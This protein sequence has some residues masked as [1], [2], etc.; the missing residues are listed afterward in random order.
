MITS[1]NALQH[2]FWGVLDS[3]YTKREQKDGC[4]CRVSCALA[5]EETGGCYVSDFRGLSTPP[6]PACWCKAE[7][8]Q[9]QI[10]PSLSSCPALP[11]PVSPHLA[12]YLAFILFFLCLLPLPESGSLTALLSC[13]TD[14]S[15]LAPLGQPASGHHSGTASV[16]C[17]KPKQLSSASKIK[18]EFCLSYT[19]SPVRPLPIPSALPRSF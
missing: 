17:L 7:V 8:T 3:T 19:L 1:A 11:C 16:S 12:I 10:V 4:F 6:G 18:S 15:P 14:C 5:G 9:C 2:I 13:W